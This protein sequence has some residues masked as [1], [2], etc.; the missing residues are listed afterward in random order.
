MWGGEAALSGEVGDASTH[1]ETAHAI[2]AKGL[3]CA[4]PGL[5]ALSGALWLVCFVLFSCGPSSHLTSLALSLQVHD[6]LSIISKIQT[7]LQTKSWVLLLTYWAVKRNQHKVIW[8]LFIPFA[9]T[10]DMF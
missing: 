2:S 7:S 4:G 8:S 1:H 3:L 9:M 10:V 5:K 6:P